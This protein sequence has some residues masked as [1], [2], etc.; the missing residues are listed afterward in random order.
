[1]R[2]SKH[3]VSEDDSRG[4]TAIEQTRHSENSKTLRRVSDVTKKISL[5]LQG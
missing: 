1:M 4:V 2:Q 3:S 5:T